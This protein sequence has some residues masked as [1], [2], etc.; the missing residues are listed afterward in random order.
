MDKVAQKSAVLVTPPKHSPTLTRGAYSIHLMSIPSTRSA[1]LLPMASSRTA[2]SSLFSATAFNAAARPASGWTPSSSF[3]SA[4]YFSSRSHHLSSTIR[5]AGTNNIANGLCQ[6]RH[7]SLDR[8][9]S[10]LPSPLSLFSSPIASGGSGG[11][12]SSSNDS[13]PYAQSLEISN[14]PI[15]KVNTIINIVPQGKRMVVERFGKLHA[16]HESGYF[17]AIPLVDTI[18][19]V[20]DVRERAVDIPN[21]SAITRDNVSVEVSG[22]L[23]VRVADPER[24]AYGARNPL[25]AV[26]MVSL[27]S[28]LFNVYMSRE[29]AHVLIDPI[30]PT[31]THHHYYHHVI[32]M[33]NLPCDRPSVNWNSTK[34]YTIV[35][36]LILSSRVQSKKQPWHGDLR[37]VVMN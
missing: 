8:P 26:I 23:F 6:R 7:Y 37:Y 33:L 21:Q 25:Y 20:I 3:Y 35:L 22:N 13:S 4:H 28:L 19:Y 14:W 1:H 36:A 27:L 34:Y 30:S 10:G 15:T 12:R 18:A 5:Y 9:N 31:T 11:A 16:I 17:I 2:L 24:A 32:S 29:K